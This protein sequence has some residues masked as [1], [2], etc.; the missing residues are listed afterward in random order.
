MQRG[1]YVMS[2][3]VRFRQ[4]CVRLSI[5]F[6]LDTAA[7]SHEIVVRYF[8]ECM[9]VLLMNIYSI[10]HVTLGLQS[11]CSPYEL[12]EACGGH[13]WGLAD[14]RHG[15]PCHAV[16]VGRGDSPWSVQLPRVE[17][18]VLKHHVSERSYRTTRAFIDAM[19]LLLL[20]EF[21]RSDLLLMNLQYAI[22]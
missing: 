19:L 7:R 4:L 2:T 17:L 5:D 3:L 11:T 1:Q 12:C 18:A 16:P 10:M 14:T 13:P 21:I 20:S 22:C 9:C 8:S 15:K 6:Q